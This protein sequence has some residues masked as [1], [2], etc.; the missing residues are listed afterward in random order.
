MVNAQLMELVKKIVGNPEYQK[1]F[2][3]CKTK[4]EMFDYC[5][6]ICS[7]YTQEEFYD[8][9]SEMLKN[10]PSEKGVPVSN[11]NLKSVSGGKFSVIEHEIW[12]NLFDNSIDNMMAAKAFT[13]IFA[14]NLKTKDIGNMLEGTAKTLSDINFQ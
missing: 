10:V 8:F 14:D 12:T 2:A 9:L 1:E 3:K 13:Q 4:Q 11:Q 5:S 6:S 7:G